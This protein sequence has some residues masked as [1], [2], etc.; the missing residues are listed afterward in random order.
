MQPAVP[1]L[2]D[3]PFSFIQTLALVQVR[4]EDIPATYAHVDL[5]R[6]DLAHIR[7]QTQIGHLQ[8]PVTVHGSLEELHGIL[9]LLEL[10]I[11]GSDLGSDAAHAGVALE[12]VCPA[13]GFLVHHLENVPAAFLRGG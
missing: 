12:G 8:S 2:I 9:C 13:L 5:I 6:K 11:G 10:P 7:G 3:R 1:V 4:R